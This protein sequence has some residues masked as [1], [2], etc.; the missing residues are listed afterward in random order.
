MSSIAP[1]EQASLVAELEEQLRWSQLLLRA[2]VDNLPSAVYAKDLEGRK[3]LANEVDCKNAGVTKEADL[4]GKT[5]F[6]FFPRQIA[7]KFFEDDCK[8]LKDGRSVIDREETFTK[9]DG[10]E[11][12][13]RTSKIPI[14]NEQGKIVGLV[15]FG[16]DI[17]IEKQLEIQNTLVQEKIREQQA[18]V[19]KMMLDL[20]GI[21]QRIGELVNGITYI[22]KQTKMVSINAAIESARVGEQGRG[23][24]IVAEEVG[25]L[26]DQSS[27][28]A[29]QVK[30]AINEVDSLVRDILALWEE[31]KLEG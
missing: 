6:D 21:P 7:Q 30:D 27:N 16:H 18:M 13:L 10:S 12:W 5:D 20:A 14:R 24:Q 1:E 11:G 3:I 28:S 2:V 8:V 22:A 19:E 29:S 31:V 23:F 17:T 4:L 25:R 9:E 15:G 26:S